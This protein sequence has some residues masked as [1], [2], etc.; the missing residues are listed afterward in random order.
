MTPFL[1]TALPFLHEYDV[2]MPN[3][4]GERKQA[5]TNICFSF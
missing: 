1:D 3:F 5:T 2:I 4:D